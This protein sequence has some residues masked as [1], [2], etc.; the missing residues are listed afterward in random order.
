M[1]D[2]V[3]SIQQKLAK[4]LPDMEITAFTSLCYAT[5][6]RQAALEELIRVGI[7]LVLVVGSP[8][9]HNSQMLRRK[10]ERSNIPSYAIDYPSEILAEWFNPTIRR[11]GMTSGASVQERFLDS[12]SAWFKDFGAKIIEQPPVQDESKYGTFT[13]PKED[14]NRLRSRWQ[15]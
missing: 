5:T 11:V 15:I 12:V 4:K 10:G 13:L 1:P 3:I 9:S 8:E 6:N 14:I 2:D 7:D